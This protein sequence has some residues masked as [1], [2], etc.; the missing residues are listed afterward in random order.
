MYTY[1]H[2]AVV[3]AALVLGGAEAG[4][5]AD[6]EVVPGREVRRSVRH[7]SVHVLGSYLKQWNRLLIR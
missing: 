7:R 2:F 6:G 1:W 3:V 5:G 4:G